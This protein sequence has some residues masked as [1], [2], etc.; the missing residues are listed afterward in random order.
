MKTKKSILKSHEVI[1]AIA[2]ILNINLSSGADKSDSLD[3]IKSV[4]LSVF[5]GASINNA[6]LY[7]L[8]LGFGIDASV[9][10][11][12][13]LYTCRY[14]HQDVETLFKSPNESVNDIGFL[15][16]LYKQKRMWYADASM[17]ISAVFGNQQGTK[18]PSGGWF[19]P[20][21]YYESVPYSTIGIPFEV[22]GMLKRKFIG[23]GMGLKGNINTEN[24]YYGLF[25]TAKLSIPTF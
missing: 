7:S 18:L 6:D 16:G 25:L 13:M 17:G 3:V 5:G 22:N 14:I 19:D 20:S 23:I 1:I 8:G 2:L 21:S 9:N 11:K 24:S 12:K 10:T 15:M 4:N